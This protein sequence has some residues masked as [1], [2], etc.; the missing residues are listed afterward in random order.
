MGKYLF[1]LLFSL[2]VFGF[3]VVSFLPNLIGQD[4][5]LL[6]ILLR[7]VVFL[8]S[9]YFVI[10]NYKKKNFAFSKIFIVYAFFWFLYFIRLF[11]DNLY[12]SADLFVPF[13]EYLFF[14]ICYTFLPSLAFFRRFDSET[15]EISSYFFIGFA[16]ITNFFILAGVLNNIRNGFL[17]STNSI[18][19]MNYIL[20]GT[21]GVLLA[22]FSLL[23]LFNNNK[24]KVSHFLFYL[25]SFL[26]GLTNALYSGSRGVFFSLLIQI[27][28]IFYFNVKMGNI[29]KV[30]IFIIISLVFG[31]INWN[32]IYSALELTLVRLEISAAQSETGTEVR[33]NYAS[34]GIN[35]FLD[36]PVLGVGLTVPEI[37]DHPHNQLIDGFTSTGILG[38]IL[39]LFLFVYGILCSFVIV[40]ENP[41]L[42][43]IF[44]IFFTAL[45]GTLSSG[46]IYL[47]GFYY[48]MLAMVFGL[49]SLKSKLRF[50]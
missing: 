13:E 7:I 46:T 39:N 16:I 11:Y 15:I 2:S 45:F 19:R 49:K 34:A 37:G 32:I 18:S 33:T 27:F 14:S 3:P 44:F 48:S 6:S 29:R 41:K 38:G 50:L 1:P 4:T 40:R 26:L 21:C 47:N 35:A 43:W 25:A 28:L 22:S 17:T 31:F 42:L 5:R 23:K 30:S 10:L 9:A 8:L 24:N 20:S 12:N 36:N